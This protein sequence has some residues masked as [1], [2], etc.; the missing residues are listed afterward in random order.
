[1][2]ERHQ[3]DSPASVAVI[4]PVYNRSDV[5]R[6][7]LAALEAQDYPSSRLTVVVADDGSDEDIET[8]VSEWEPVFSKRYSRQEH[9]GFGAGRARNLGAALV[10]S[11]VLV[12]LDSDGITVPDFVA[13]HAAWHAENPDTVVIGGRFH[14]Q[15]EG[16][17]LADLAAGTVDMGPLVQDERDDFRSV[18]SR[19]TS[20]FKTA[21][22]GYRAFVSSNVS[23]S[24]RLFARS[25]GFDERFRWWGSED[26]EFGWRLWQLGADFV[27]DPDARIFHQL[28]SDTAGGME[29]RQRARELNRGLLVSLVPHSFYR[30]G[31]PDP[32]PEVPKFSVLVNEV[33]AGA[34]PELWR[35]LATQTLPDF[36]VIF[37]AE[38]RDHDPFAGAAQGDPRI[39][40]IADTE[41]AIGASRG[42]HL[43]WINGHSAPGPT[44]LQNVRR[45]LKSRPAAP[46]LTI[47]VAIP[48]EQ[49][50]YSS[51]ADLDH[52]A[53]RW[54]SA[55][56]L[57]IAVRRRELVRALDRGLTPR[58]ALTIFAHSEQS[59]HTRQALV[60]LPASTRAPRPDDFAYG[61]SVAKQIWE[62][63]QLG[64]AQALKAGARVAR[65]R[66]R[67]TRPPVPREITNQEQR[68]GVRYVGWVGKGN[69]GDEAMLIA[70][71]ELLRWGN[72][73][74]RGE[75]GDLLLLGG[76][77]LINRNQY[78]RWLTE[79]ESP[80][81]ERAVLGTGVASPDF[82]GITEDNAEWLRWL[83]T[84]AYV[85][86]RGPQSAETLLHWGFKGDLEICGDPALALHPS[87]DVLRDERIVVAPAA[88]SGELWGGS[89]DHVVAEI[90]EA[91]RVWIKEGREVVLMSS[92]PTDDRQI[93]LIRD[94]L[95]GGPVSYHSGYSST[96]ESLE[97]VASAGLVVGERLHACV[98]AAA[99]DRP[100]VGLEYRPKVRDFADSV[101]MGDYVIRTD[102]LSAG[103]LIER[104]SDLR[105]GPP[106][107]MTSSVTTYRARLAE[108]SQMIHDAVGA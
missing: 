22:E 25:G 97:L 103:S 66:L 80:R 89:D 84:C 78:L 43:I 44:L 4:I 51:R 7:T 101:A 18:L 42:E 86:V 41:M 102:D 98:L 95:E 83:G 53:D 90:S 106:E 30:A 31:M 104:A 19:R 13:R 71:R 57:V 3:N 24:R 67:P 21:D 81:I 68:P 35:S 49:S 72:I 12:F 64:P 92:H 96:D 5:L 82:W 62:E 88:T 40:F 27:H 107:A 59:L 87:V 8:L 76:G 32:L 56:P 74:V 45:R 16:M 93:I 63:V 20:G 50:M 105:A 11:E 85:G 37:Q 52:L 2:T 77:T 54:E 38:G 73:E 60:A 29:G 10:E 6:R 75:A 79:R 61:K 28:D 69:L 46:A 1:V 58:E 36:E 94:R 47:G 9:D 48:S 14:L 100:F 55:L 70:T 17:R 91:I 108:A 15:A 65:Q 34:P 33:P 23:L 26:T 39:R 99:A